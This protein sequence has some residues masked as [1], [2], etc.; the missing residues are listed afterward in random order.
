MNEY[1]KPINI[2]EF[3][4]KIRCKEQYV[5]LTS[6]LAENDVHFQCDPTAETI[7]HFADNIWMIYIYDVIV[8]T[9]ENFVKVL[10]E[11]DMSWE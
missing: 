7:D 3:T 8:P 1:K 10:K 11:W 4:I 6:W 5:A 2:T 9:F